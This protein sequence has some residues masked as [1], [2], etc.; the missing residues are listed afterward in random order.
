MGQRLD[1]FIIRELLWSDIVPELL[2]TFSHSQKITKKWIKEN[3]TWR[4]YDVSVLR[5]WSVQKRGWITEYM[6][7]QMLRGGA[8][9]GAFFNGRLVG[10]CC[11]DGVISGETARYANM[12]MLFVDDNWK[13]RGIG[14]LL[15]RE[16]CPHATR[17]GAEKMFI[18]AIPAMETIAFYQKMG[19][20]DAKEIVAGF[21]D[22]ADDRYMEIQLRKMAHE[23]VG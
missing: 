3:D 7:Q 14:S 10:F 4:I 16:I 22:S 18:S 11:L 12:S 20:C 2:K 21:V 17:I 5:E 15:F 1:E 13:R 19:C 23:E 6:G 8:V 9:I